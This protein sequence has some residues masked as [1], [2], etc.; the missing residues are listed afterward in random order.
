MAFD[1]TWQVYTQEKYEDFLKAIDIKPITEIHQTGNTFV[2]TSK[3][4]NKSCTVNLKDGKLIA[5]SDK[6]IHEQQI[7]GNEMVEPISHFSPTDYFLWL[8]HIHPKEQEDLNKKGDNFIFFFVG[9]FVR[10]K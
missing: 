9:A 1:G 2:I 4:T 7:V 10:E 8:S 3:T 6:F 5:K